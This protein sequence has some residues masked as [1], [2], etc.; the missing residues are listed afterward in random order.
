MVPQIDCHRRLL[1]WIVELP[2]ISVGV[3]FRSPKGTKFILDYGE[4]VF[5]SGFL[6]SSFLRDTSS[7]DWYR[8]IIAYPFSHT[9]ILW[10][11]TCF[12]YPCLPRNCHITLAN[13]FISLSDQQGHSLILNRPRV[14]THL[15]LPWPFQ[16][17][18]TDHT[19]TV[20]SVSESC[21]SKQHCSFEHRR[22]RVL[23]K[24]GAHSLEQNESVVHNSTRI[25]IQSYFQTFH[26]ISQQKCKQTNHVHF[27]SSSQLAIPKIPMP[28]PKRFGQPRRREKPTKTAS[29]SLWLAEIP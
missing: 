16:D 18:T 4:L 8:G 17:E 9:L 26:Q 10:K 29:R 5:F 6:K 22:N 28:W 27:L 15:L 7:S 19:R 13:H 20:W 3:L 24:R 2:A 1:T 14:P 12:S 21:K 11:Q 25:D 23:A